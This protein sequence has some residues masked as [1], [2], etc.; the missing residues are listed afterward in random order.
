[1]HTDIIL[2]NGSLSNDVMLG[3]KGAVEGIGP[4]NSI[5]GGMQSFCSSFYVSKAVSKHHGLLKIILIMINVVIIIITVIIIL[6][7]K[8]L[9]KLHYD[10]P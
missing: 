10:L 8:L 7:L 9:Q 4:M 1:M 2:C 3:G 6:H 5:C